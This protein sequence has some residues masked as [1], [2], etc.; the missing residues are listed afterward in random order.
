[1]PDTIDCHEILSF[2]VNF[3]TTKLSTHY[4]NMGTLIKI[5][6]NYTELHREF[7]EIH[8]VKK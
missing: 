2:V 5:T 3:F 1:M 7:T 4:Y 8:R 6:F